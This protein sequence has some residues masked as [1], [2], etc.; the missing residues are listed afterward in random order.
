MI[1]INVTDADIMEMR[2]AF[3]PLVE[4]M[5]SYN[6]LNKYPQPSQYMAW[7]DEATR[8]LQDVD[9]PYMNEM[10][11][12]RSCIP[13][14]LTP[15]PTAPSIDFEEELKRLCDTPTVIVEEHIRFMMEFEGESDLLNYALAHPRQTID[16]LVDELRTYWNRTL[17]HHWSRMTAI[18]EN[19]I[20]YRA[21]E[22]ALYGASHMLNGLHPRFSY[23]DGAIYIKKKNVPSTTSCR[24]DGLQY[25]IAGR[26][27]QV[28][29]MIFSF[30][31][32]YWQIG[33]TYQPMVIYGARGTGLWHYSEP[34]N[35]DEALQI[36]LG[37]GR[38]R[39]FYA[40]TT[41]RST[42]EL[43]YL[44]KIT[45]GAVSQHLN[46]LNQAGLVESSRSGKRVFYRLSQR[47][48]KLIELFT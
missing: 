13:D 8:A 2:F 18:L 33:D 37:V 23:D 36:T 7:V 5:T 14:F 12:G 43:A 44:L 20:L 29:P 26:G 48:Q 15:T 31:H 25:D 10:I 45:A 19:D 41:P 38:S 6:M 16:A 47:G 35:P 1:A 24:I 32:M 22:Q 28:V 30:P 42:N 39:V 3:S 4:A 17:A 27:L 11:V 34:D 21:R 9:L 40:L 46:K